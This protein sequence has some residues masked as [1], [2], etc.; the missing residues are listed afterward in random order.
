MPVGNKCIDT[1]QTDDSRR[2]GGSNWNATC[3]EFQTSPGGSSITAT[4]VLSRCS[5]VL[6]AQV[7]I[8]D[9]LPA[10]FESSAELM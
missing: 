6:T 9:N 5:A 8:A 1:T 3:V 10:L 2:W 7:Y 4:R